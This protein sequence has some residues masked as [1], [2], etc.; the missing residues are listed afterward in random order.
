MEAYFS[1]ARL[2]F[3]VRVF[4]LGMM[5]YELVG[6]GVHSVRGRRSALFVYRDPDGHDL[7][8]QMNQ[9]SLTELPAGGELHDHEG[10]RFVVYRRDGLTLVF[11]REG[12]VL[13]V[14]VG[15]GGTDVVLALA[16]AKAARATAG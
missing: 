8:C 6:G 14:L 13:C 9:G 5:R 7:I 15:E 2:A 4:D 10:I 16:S 11:W 12:R 3:P 1:E